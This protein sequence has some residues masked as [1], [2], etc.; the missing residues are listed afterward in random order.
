MKREFTHSQNGNFKPSWLNQVLNFWLLGRIWRLSAGVWFQDLP[1][2]TD[3][4]LRHHDASLLNRDLCLEL[5]LHRENAGV[6]AILARISLLGKAFLELLQSPSQNDKITCLCRKVWKQTYEKSKTQMSFHKNKRLN[7][8]SE[9]C[10]TKP[11]NECKIVYSPLDIWETPENRV[12][13]KTCCQCAE[14]RVLESL[15]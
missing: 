7:F 14:T 9:L 6:K 10:G 4:V 12:E 3:L 8:L 2:K 5:T 15:R 13:D 11:I 1:E